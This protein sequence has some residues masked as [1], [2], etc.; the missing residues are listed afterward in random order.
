MR[1]EVSGFFLLKQ[2]SEKLR[3]LFLP[4][5]LSCFSRFLRALQKNRA[6]SRLI[7]LLTNVES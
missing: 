1:G 6:H 7:F 4:T 2:K 3:L 5:L